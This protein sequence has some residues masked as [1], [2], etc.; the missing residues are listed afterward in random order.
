MLQQLIQSKLYK[1]INFLDNWRK[2]KIR[3]CFLIIIKWDYVRIII[4]IRSRAE[5]HVRERTTVE[6]DFTI[7]FKQS[8]YWND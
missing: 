1:E 8:F 4:H 7:L 3:L 6:K 5:A 2:Y